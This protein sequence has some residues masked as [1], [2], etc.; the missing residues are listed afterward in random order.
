MA[1]DPRTIGTATPTTEDGR[2]YPKR[3]RAYEAF[4]GQL[5]PR[6]VEL[7]E[8]TPV[9]LAA[10]VKDRRLQ[11]VALQWLMSA[12]W[13]SLIERTDRDIRTPRTYRAT[14]YGIEKFGL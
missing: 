5:F 9:Q 3:L 6:L 13:R 4:D 7:G 12:E 11:T 1:I 2:E 14:Q 8:A 10:S